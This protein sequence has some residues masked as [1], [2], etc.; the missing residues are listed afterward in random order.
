M[1]PYEIVLIGATGFTGAL[2]ARYLAVN[3][4]EDMR[5]AVAGRDPG[6]LDGVARRLSEQSAARVPV[7]A[8]YADVTD[9]SSLRSL[10]SSANVVASAVGPFA[11]LGEPLVAACADAGTD[12]VDICGESEFIDRMWLRHH[13]RARSSG[14]RIVHSCG[15][16]SVPPDLGVWFTLR[17]LP[18]GV[19]LQV[20]GFVRARAR[21]SAGTYRSAMAAFADSRPAAAAAAERRRNESGVHGRRVGAV[22]RNLR[23][24]PG[25]NRWAL[26]LPTIDPSVVRRSARASARYGPDFRYGHYVSVGGLPAVAAVVGGLS[27]VRLLARAAPT[28]AGLL[29]LLSVRDGPSESRRQDSW[30]RVRFVGTGAGSRVVTEVSGGDPGYD[31]TAKMLAESAMCLA[32]D[33]LPARAGQLTTVEA[34]GDALLARLQHAGMTFRV[35]ELCR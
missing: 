24:E 26:R 5:W 17:Y 13:Q 7:G 29:T 18:E 33:D 11:T 21:L 27:A 10:A 1:A 32:R 22:R 3:A 35:L 34:M 6:R 25:T 12:Y 31:E 14:A 28:R 19:P 15:F 23:R 20:E 8:I 16:D 9:P 4:P 2:T 30:F